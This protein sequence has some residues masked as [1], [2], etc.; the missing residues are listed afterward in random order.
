MLKLLFKL[1]KYIHL[2]FYVIGFKYM[3]FKPI[4]NKLVVDKRYACVQSEWVHKSKKEKVHIYI[5][6]YTHAYVCVYI[7]IYL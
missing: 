7:Y 2:Y 5:Y 4:K 6:I 1:L 3:P